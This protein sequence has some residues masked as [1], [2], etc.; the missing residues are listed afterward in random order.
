[1]EN[2]FLYERRRLYRRLRRKRPRGAAMNSAAER[3]RGRGDRSVLAWYGGLGVVPTIK[4]LRARM[5]HVRAAELSGA[6]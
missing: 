2:V 3:D 4:E 5:D 1:M 6:A